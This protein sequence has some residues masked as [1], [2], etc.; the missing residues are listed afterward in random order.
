MAERGD[1]GHVLHH[2]DKRAGRGLRECETIEHLAGT[3][4]GEGFHGALCKVCEHRIRTTERDHRGLAEEHALLSKNTVATVGCHHREY[5]GEPQ[6]E[7]NYQNGDQS[8][9]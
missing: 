1:K 6:H 2:H 7:A 5:R 8:A 3:E 4:P 9:W